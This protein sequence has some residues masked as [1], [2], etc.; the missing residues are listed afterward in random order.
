MRG[1]QTSGER[2]FI[3]SQNYIFHQKIIIFY[4]VGNKIT[5]IPSE[6]GLATSLLEIDVGE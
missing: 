4:V 2:V 3:R 1:S 5:S 6:I